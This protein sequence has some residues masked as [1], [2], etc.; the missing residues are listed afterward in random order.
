MPNLD[1]TNK[2]QLGVN[3]FT[4]DQLKSIDSASAGALLM[5]GLMIKPGQRGGQ[6]CT[7]QN[8]VIPTTIFNPSRSDPRVEAI[9][10]EK[11]YSPKKETLI[12]DKLRAELEKNQNELIEL[13]TMMASIM[14][15][16]ETNAPEAAAEPTVDVAALKAELKRYKDKEAAMKEKMEKARAGRGKTN[17][18]NVTTTA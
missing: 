14:G 7:T 10:G 9:K 15:G 8:G 6:Y 13:R 4:S 3:D 2:E 1:V 5:Y 17:K 11:I 12:T 16:R 18:K